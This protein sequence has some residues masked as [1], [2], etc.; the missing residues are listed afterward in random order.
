MTDDDR[1]LGIA[2]LLLAA[3]I[4]NDRHG[5]ADPEDDADTALDRAQHLIQQW[6]KRTGAAKTVEQDVSDAVLR[7]CVALA[8]AKNSLS[9]GAQLE[10][11]LRARAARKGELEP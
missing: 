2:A 7:D 9:L 6:E 3:E 1:L 10:T 5:M 11:I 8:Y 4:T